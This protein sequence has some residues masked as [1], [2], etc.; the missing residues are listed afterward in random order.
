MTTSPL[1]T[2]LLSS[3]TAIF[4]LSLVLR[5]LL[6]AYSHHQDT[7]SALKY[8]DIDYYVFTDAAKAVWQ[9]R[10]PYERETYRYT[11]LLAWMLVPSAVWFDFGKVVFILADLVAGWLL[12]RVLLM[13][14]SGSG[15]EDG[16][17]KMDVGRALRYVSACW[18]LNPMVMGISTRGSSEGLLG[19]LAAGILLAG[20]Q[21][22]VLMAGALVG[23]AVHFKIYPFI[24]GVSLLWWMEPRT[25]GEKGRANSAGRMGAGERTIWQRAWGFV[26]WE[27][28]VFSVSALATFMFFNVAMWVL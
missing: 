9:G 18:L 27:R 24:Y 19:V 22:R 17:K 6:L 21:R 26:T 1:A 4:T 14:K 7:H 28:I 23:F 5:L 11:P 8:T 15:S 25:R 16:G 10:S 12:V 20:L 13:T 2:S 3:P